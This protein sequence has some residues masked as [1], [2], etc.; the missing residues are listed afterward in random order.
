VTGPY[1]GK[2]ALQRAEIERAHRYVRWS[3]RTRL[4]VAWT[5]A[6]LVLF[7]VWFLLTVPS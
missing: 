5:G 6:W 1:A 7:L 4:L 3:R 2:A